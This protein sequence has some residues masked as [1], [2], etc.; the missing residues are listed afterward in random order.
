MT[1]LE[2]LIALRDAVEAGTANAKQFQ[3]V[4]PGYMG[5]TTLRA[6]KAREA[7]GGSLDAALALKDA[8][9]PGWGW[10]AGDKGTVTVIPPE[11]MYAETGLIGPTCRIA[12][13][14]AR[15]MLLAILAALIAQAGANEGR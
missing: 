5:L 2:A 14:P 1:Q 10:M 8:V 15:A 6:V 12:D 3:A 7:Y 4:W 11:R 9:L 13:D